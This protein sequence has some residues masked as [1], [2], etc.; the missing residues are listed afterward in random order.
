[1]SGE[2]RTS[3]GAKGNTGPEAKDNWGTRV[4]SWPH[5][6]RL[7]WTR[8]T[9]VGNPH[10]TGYELPAHRWMRLGWRPEG[11]KMGCLRSWLC[12]VIL[13]IAALT[14]RKYRYRTQRG[15]RWE[16]RGHAAARVPEMIGSWS[17][18]AVG[19]WTEWRTLY[20]GGTCWSTP[21]P[22][23]TTHVG[24]RWRNLRTRRSE[25]WPGRRLRDGFASGGAQRRLAS[26]WAVQSTSAR[27]R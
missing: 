7:R 21:C 3:G 27:R 18:G 20:T 1:M 2:K 12:Y 10:E 13:T 19:V 14:A 6:G 11:W 5:V 8:A 23:F 16:E 9:E 25:H 17:A 15:G 24:G 4:N 26:G 22:H